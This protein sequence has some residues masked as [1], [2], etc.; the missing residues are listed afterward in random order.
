MSSATLCGW[1]ATRPHPPW[2][3]DLPAEFT[4][5]CC[6]DAAAWRIERDSPAVLT[7]GRFR[8]EQTADEVPRQGRSLKAGFAARTPC[9]L[10]F[11]PAEVSGGTDATACAPAAG[12]S[13]S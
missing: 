6:S 4:F 11:A 10:R 13:A 2:R 8:Y 1:R 12:A 3:S 5:A 7:C 9:A